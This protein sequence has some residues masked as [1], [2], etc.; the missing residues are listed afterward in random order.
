MWAGGLSK[1]NAETT[2]VVLPGG[3]VN[4]PASHPA[5][6]D[7]DVDKSGGTPVVGLL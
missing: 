3:S 1:Q 6:A 2:T 4:T 5:P 7:A